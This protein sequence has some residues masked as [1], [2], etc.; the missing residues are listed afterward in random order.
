MK[1]IFLQLVFWFGLFFMLVGV[2][3]VIKAEDNKTADKPKFTGGGFPIILDENEWPSQLVYD[4]IG[5]CYQGTIR[6][7]L[8]TNPSLMGQ[9]PGPM[10]QRQMVEH[11]FC[12]MDKVRK[13]QSI[14]EYKENVFNS[15][16]I[17]NLFMVKAL[18]CVADYHTLPTFFATIPTPDNKTK[19]DNKTVNPT[20][21]PDGETEDSQE[22]SPDQEQEESEGFPQT[23]FQG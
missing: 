18:E 20:E 23:I 11:C 5:A 19:S 22:E 6:W 10:A 14:K 12:V 2:G 9:A 1:N 15:E 13:E 17:G 8:L 16:F 7:I 21:V 3:E 4:T